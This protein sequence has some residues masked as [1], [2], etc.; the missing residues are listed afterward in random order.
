MRIWLSIILG[1]CVA[2]GCG[3]KKDKDQG[4]GSG[5]APAAVVADAVPSGPTVEVFIDD[6]SVAKVTADQIAAWP[7]LDGLVPEDSG[8]LGTWLTVSLTTGKP[9]PTEVARP[10]ANYPDKVPVLFPGEGGAPAFGM[11]DPV[12]LAK[13]GTPA[14]RE[15]GVREIRIKLAKEGRMGDHQG[16]AGASGDPMKLVIAIKTPGGNKSITGAQIL[17]LPREPQPGSE[18]TKGWRVTQILAAAGVKDYTSLVLLD[19]GGA[20]VPLEKDDFND[21]TSVPFVKLNK[22]GAM[23]FRLMKKQGDGWQ[24]SGDLRSLVTIQVK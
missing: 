10:S 21:K 20:S 13:K 9:A 7:R 12:E 22:Q 6:V 1:T 16:G 19:A 8:R 4:G 11:F 23:R 15:D 18:D 14:V 5:S 3:G 2:L 17:A 24:A